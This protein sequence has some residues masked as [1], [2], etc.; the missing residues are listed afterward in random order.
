MLLILNNN[1]YFQIVSVNRIAFWRWIKFCLY[2]VLQA[3]LI[4]IETF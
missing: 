1:I 2:Y 4:Y 3:I